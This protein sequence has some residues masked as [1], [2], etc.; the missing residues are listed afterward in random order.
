[1][2]PLV[3]VSLLLGLLSSCVTP[4]P[5]CPPV[6]APDHVSTVAV[7]AFTVDTTALPDRGLKPLAHPSCMKQLLA[8]TEHIL[9]GKWK[10]LAASAFGAAPEYLEPA[11]NASDDPRSTPAFQGNPMPHRPPL[12]PETARSLCRSLQVDA[13]VTADIHWH[14]EPGPW[15]RTIRATARTRLTFFDARGDAFYSWDHRAQ[16]KRPL[17]KTPDQ[18]VLDAHAVEDWI[19]ASLD[20]IRDMVDPVIF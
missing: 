20:S 8:G 12:A 17:G 11:P 10:V 7:V 9:K 18:A 1:M 5:V 4:A 13:V 19:Q 2:K 3:V 15:K 16:A 14:L 6:A